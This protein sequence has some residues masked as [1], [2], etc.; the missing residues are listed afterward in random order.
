MLTRVAAPEVLAPRIASGYAAGKGWR[1]IAE[2]ILPVVDG[3][4]ST[5]RR[6]ARTEGLRIAS[7]VNEEH[8]E[9]LG[10]DAIAGY[11]LLATLDQFSRPWHAARHGQVYYRSPKP[12]QKGFAQMP[13]PPEEP[14]DPSER[15][16]G[17]PRTAW[18]CLLPDNFVQGRFVSAVKAQYAGKA[19]EL[20]CVSG[21]SVRLTANHPVLT[22]EGF[23]PA[24][25][26]QKGDYLGR[27]IERIADWPEDEHDAPKSVEKV[28]GAVEQFARVVRRRPCALEEF[29]G[30]AAFFK[31]DVD[32]VRADGELLGGVVAKAAKGR[33][34]A[35]LVGRGVRAASISG[36]GPGPL[37]NWRVG[38][39]P[40]CLVS[41][42]D[43]APSGVNVSDPTPFG[44]LG[45]GLV[46][47]S[48][49]HVSQVSSD[50][51]SVNAKVF[52]Q[53]IDRYA[54]RVPLGDLRV[55]QVDSSQE[56]VRLRSPSNAHPLLDEPDFQ[57]VS[58]DAHFPPEALQSFAGQI[59]A[60]E[61]VRVDVFH[62]DGPVFDFETD[63]GYY[64]SY[65]TG[66]GNTGIVL[67]NCRCVIVPILTPLSGTSPAALARP[68]PDPLTYGRWFDEAD[69][70]RR[71][72]AV[73]T[74]R[75][76]AVAEDEGEPEWA[77]F[78]DPSDG[79]LLPLDA[80]RAET[81]DARR[82][83]VAKVKAMLGERARLARAA[84]AHG[85]ALGF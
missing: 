28:F 21:L 56:D 70:K 65:S 58:L 23:V 29:H 55:R 10:S 63:T 27:Y 72:I 73:G 42:F 66:R 60:D 77:H 34:Y 61:V 25:R 47:Q 81:A 36:G 18:N 67:S 40:S 45:F 3:V 49:A 12:G 22:A 44:L 76:S 78:I 62:Y 26:V 2:D 9:A 80:L 48:D 85:G 6:V 59:A 1:E 82:G 30:D 53:L 74:R 52:G 83:R 31:G 50:G 19:I 39:A 37:H 51:R 75:Y 11:Q 57:G 43:L 15:P 16:A 17:T 8:F 13:R 54:R 38:L 41:R 35:T 68:V 46:P 79:D 7:A 14:A 71:R 20:T 4:R 32:V 24:N 5:A 64:L 33:G 84:A 69:E